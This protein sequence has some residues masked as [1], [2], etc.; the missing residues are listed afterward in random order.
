MMCLLT[1]SYIPLLNFLPLTVTSAYLLRF[2]IILMIHY[3]KGLISS[4]LSLEG[5]LWSKVPR[6]SFSVLPEVF[7]FVSEDLFDSLTVHIPS[8]THSNQTSMAN[9]RQQCQD[10]HWSSNSFDF[11]KVEVFAKYCPFRT[12]YAQAMFISFC[13]K[14]SSY[15]VAVCTFCCSTPRSTRQFVKCW[16]MEVFEKKLQNTCKT[17]QYLID[18]VRNLLHCFENF[19]TVSKDCR[20]CLNVRFES[21]QDF[22]TFDTIS[23][24]YFSVN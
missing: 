21:L 14:I 2:L 7:E 18:F 24:T 10:R 20:R 1:S 19:H 6:F 23:L 17:W 15:W 5:S 8:H 12:W 13:L 22:T 9:F 3:C 11:M 4:L 16:L